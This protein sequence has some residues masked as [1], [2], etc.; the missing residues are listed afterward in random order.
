MVMGGYHTDCQTWHQMAISYTA[1]LKLQ[2][3]LIPAKPITNYYSMYAHADISLV[4][5]VNNHFNRMKSNLKVMEAANVGIPVIASGVNP[6]LELPINYCIRA[7][8]W[9]NHIKRLVRFPRRREDEGETLREFCDV[10]FNFEKINLERKQI[11]EY[12]NSNHS[13]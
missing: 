10:H 2:Y 9:T 8:D 6:Y 3:K 1:N 7:T 12:E 13:R 5:L 4:P 11:L